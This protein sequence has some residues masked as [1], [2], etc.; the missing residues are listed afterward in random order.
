MNTTPPS[1]CRFNHVMLIDDNDI[2]NL[3]NSR[4]MTSHNFAAAVDV[5]TSTESALVSLRLM[6]EESDNLPSIIFLDLQM[7]VLD[8]FA[9]LDEFET[10]SDAVKSKCKIVVLSS[11]ISPDDINRASTHKYVI[12]YINKPLS[13]MYLDAITF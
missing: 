13:E 7:P 12:K 5:K 6:T 2:D 9:F 8:G 11:S 10:M 1:G 3:I 4:I